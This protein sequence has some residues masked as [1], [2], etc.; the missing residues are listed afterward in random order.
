VFDWFPL[1][2]M[3]CRENFAGSAGKLIPSGVG[4]EWV[5]GI[6]FLNF[7]GTEGLPEFLFRFS[8]RRKVLRSFFFAFRRD[9]RLTGV[10]FL[11][12]GGTEGSPTFLFCFSERR[13]ACRSSENGKRNA[14]KPSDV[15]GMPSGVKGMPADGPGW[16]GLNARAQS[17]VKPEPEKTKAQG[18]ARPGRWK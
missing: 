1:G 4:R 9:G 12:F 17:P 5:F 10:S 14:L 8:E 11:R 13:K 15:E 7:G 6:S 2:T 18:K 3:G 16:L